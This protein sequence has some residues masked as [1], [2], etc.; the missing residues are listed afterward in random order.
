VVKIEPTIHTP[1][2]TTG[3]KTRCNE[4][5]GHLQIPYHS[6]CKEAPPN[7]TNDPGTPCHNKDNLHKQKDTDT[8]HQKYIKHEQIPKEN[9]A[10]K[11]PLLQSIDNDQRYTTTFPNNTSSPTSSISPTR[12]L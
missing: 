6:S 8:I 3:T 11:S 12:Q 5:T 2:L 9:E 4:D 10:K 1:L 7:T